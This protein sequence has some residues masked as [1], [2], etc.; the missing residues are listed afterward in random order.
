MPNYKNQWTLPLGWRSLALYGLKRN[1]CS[2]DC[3]ACLSLCRA[4]HFLCRYGEENLCAH[5]V[6]CLPFG[7]TGIK[8]PRTLKQLRTTTHNVT[9]VP[10]ILKTC[11]RVSR[12]SRENISCETWKASCAPVLNKLPS[13]CVNGGE[14]QRRT[15][16]LR[17][18]TNVSQSQ[19]EATSMSRTG[20]STDHVF[21]NVGGSC[22][23]HFLLPMP[24]IQPTSEQACRPVC[25]R[26]NFAVPSCLHWWRALQRR[27][28]HG[29][30]TMSNGPAS[31]SP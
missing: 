16:S 9:H 29:P 26:N 7:G 10:H 21:V 15:T 3:Q 1:R 25:A 5:K 11:C 31:E 2:L 20:G 27:R 23:S 24:E 18:K 30:H 19:G 13:S 22:C 4:S 8:H 17:Q 6:V 12:R 14:D 28:T